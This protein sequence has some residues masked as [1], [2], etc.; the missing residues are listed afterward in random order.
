MAPRRGNPAYVKG[1]SGN[2]RGVNGSTA[3]DPK[4]RQFKETAYRD[5]IDALQRYGFMTTPELE[6]ELSRSDL[7][8]FNRMFGNLV[9][10]AANGDKEARQLLIDRLWGRVAA[11]PAMQ[12]NFSAIP[13]DKLYELAGKALRT[14]Q[15]QR[16]EV[17]DESLTRLISEKAAGNDTDTPGE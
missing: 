10:S 7:S 3:F 15:I 13:T 1:K 4:I 12:I 8:N 14:L 16:P 5:F 2:P 17:L 11:D 9:R 6:A